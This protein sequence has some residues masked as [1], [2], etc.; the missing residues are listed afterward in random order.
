MFVIEDI[1][2]TSKTGEDGK[3]K[4][5]AAFQMMQDCSELWFTSEPEFEAYMREN[6]LTQLLASRQVD[7]IR[8][9]SYGENLTITTRVYECLGYYGFR[10]TIITDEA[11]LPCYA[12]WSTGVCVN[13]ETGRLSKMDPSIVSLMCIDPKYDMKYLD[14]KIS[15]PKM[16]LKSSE[17]IMVMRD[18]IDYNRHMNN[19]QYIRIACEFLPT[20]FMVKRVRVEYKKPA[21]MG[22]ILYPQVLCIDDK[23]FVELIS[24]NGLCAVIEFTKTAE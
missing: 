12:T 4:L 16:E 13:H 6:N 10:N 21:R 5:V 18:D 24:E 22:D 20:D 8:V 23:M 3:L 14:R 19:A 17:P 15:L 7:I 1:V 9:P 2:T 11:G